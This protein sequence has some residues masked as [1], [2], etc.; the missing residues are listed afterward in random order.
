[1]VALRLLA[2]LMALMLVV[3]GLSVGLAWAWDH[4][5]ASAVQAAPVQPR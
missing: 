2:R 5:D 4:S 1:M 3:L